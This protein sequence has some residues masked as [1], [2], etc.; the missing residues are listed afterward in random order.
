MLYSIGYQ[1]KSITEFV[2][3]LRERGIQFLMDLRSKPVS[4]ITSYRQ[5]VLRSR[6]TKEGISYTWGGATLGGFKSIPESEIRRLANWQSSKVAVMMCM[7]ADPEKCHRNQIAE[8]LRRYGLDV[9]H[10]TK[11]GEY[12]GKEVDGALREPEPTE[13]AL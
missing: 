8:R 9:I 7:E 12:H 11:G 13:E 10:I 4:R 1:D 3:A 5:E 2:E 6:L